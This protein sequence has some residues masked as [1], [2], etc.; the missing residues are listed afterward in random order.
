METTNDFCST[1]GTPTARLK[2]YGTNLMT[3]GTVALKQGNTVVATKDFT[4]N[5][6]QFNTRAITFDAVTV[7]QN[8]DYTF[9][10]LAVNGVS[11]TANDLTEASTEIDVA[12]NV[13]NDITVNVYTD[14]YPTSLS[15]F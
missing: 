11:V 6:S 15:R 14:N 10:I 4:S 2:N 5:T 13:Q 1:T 3:S 8:A 7:D 9:Q 12:E